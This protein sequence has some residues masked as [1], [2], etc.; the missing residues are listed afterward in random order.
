MVTQKLKSILI[1]V[2]KGIYEVNGKSIASGCSELTLEFKKGEWSLA[3]TEDSIYS[4]SES[5]IKE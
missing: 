5:V 3:L 2:E 1:D 4:T